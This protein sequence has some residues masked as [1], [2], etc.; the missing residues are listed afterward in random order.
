MTMEKTMNISD[1]GVLLLFEALLES[2]RELYI[3]GYMV[4]KEY[5]GYIPSK[6]EF[7]IFQ[8]KEKQKFLLPNEQTRLKHMNG[9]W[10]ARNFFMKDPYDVIKMPGEKICCMLDQIA[11]ERIVEELR[12]K[13]EEKKKC[14]KK[15]KSG[16]QKT[17][18][19]EKESKGVQK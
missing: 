1:E 17:A 3:K 2:T 6:E 19:G 7:D 18:A 12:K 15:K 16:T 9:Y 14:K 13:E 8:F 10:E 4:M 5:F 11:E